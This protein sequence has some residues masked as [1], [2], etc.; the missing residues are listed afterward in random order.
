MITYHIRATRVIN[1]KI[2]VYPRTNNNLVK[3]INE[4]ALCA[5]RN[6]THRIECKNIINNNRNS[7]R[8]VVAK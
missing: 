7:E 2:N 5:V 6:R 3:S 4:I 1:N 8:R